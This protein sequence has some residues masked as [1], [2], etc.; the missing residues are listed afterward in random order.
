[1]LTVYNSGSAELQ[2]DPA[3]LV[4]PSG[5]SL[6]GSLPSSIGPGGMYTYFTVRLDAA[7]AGDYSGT[8]SFATNDPNHR[9][10][11]FT[12]SGQVIGDPAVNLA[13]TLDVIADPAAIDEDAAEQTIALT[14][15]TA[16]GTENQNLTVTATSS[17]A[18]LIAGLAVAYNS[19]NTTGTLSF[20]PV[21]DQSGTAVIT[22]TVRDD[23]G[24][25]NGGV[26]T[27]ERSFQVTVNAV[28][29]GPVLTAPIAPVT[30][31]AG[32]PLAVV[33]LAPY[34]ADADVA[35]SGDVLE[36]TAMVNVIPPDPDDADYNPALLTAS[37]VDGGLRLEFG[38]GQIGH[39]DVT[40]GASDLAG[41]FVQTVVRMTVTPVNTGNTPPT[42]ASPLEPLTLEAGAADLETD[43]AAVFADADVAAGTDSLRYSISNT[44]A[45]LLN[46]T[47]SGSLLTVSL[48][49]GQL[50]TAE[51]TLR[52]TDNADEYAETSFSVTV[53]P[54]NEP[55]TAT[56]I[57]SV[58]VDED[59][60][61][62]VLN[63]W[64]FFSDAEDADEN[65]VFDVAIDQSVRRGRRG[66]SILARVQLTL[67]FLPNASGT[68]EYAV[69]ARDTG[70][71]IA[72]ATLS[73]T[74]NPVTIRRRG[75]MRRSR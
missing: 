62:V 33:G 35:T 65:L 14:G 3:S 24:T 67:P 28:N 4:L 21:A 64:D 10:F 50:G 25:A 37:V 26:D 31:D 27:F 72:T 9:V 32:S 43:L 45:G 61:D 48:I 58:T 11:N 12:L 74:V 46:A 66:V 59:A 71:K 60:A 42:V 54:F 44:N 7:A 69:T 53:V 70:G 15:I 40:V 75:P 39:V 47:L 17:N 20:T 2:L 57:P 30:V 49:P 18:A 6:V 68:A 34:F 52:A 51:I 36:Y 22:V 8:L 23:G 55:P 16:G 73:V 41:L 19:P 38:A 29:D 13:P 56:P 1:M 63:L 5:F